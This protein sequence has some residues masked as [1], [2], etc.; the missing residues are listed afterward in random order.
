MLAHLSSGN[1]GIQFHSYE[2]TSGCILK[3]EV[4]IARYAPRCATL[5]RFAPYCG[6]GILNPGGSGVLEPELRQIVAP[7]VGR[8]QAA[9][10]IARP[11]L[12]RGRAR[13]LSFLF[14]TADEQWSEQT[15]CRSMAPVA[16]R[17][18]AA[19]GIARPN[20]RSSARP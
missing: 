15:S 13:S 3:H 7:V 11:D 18:Q 8:A 4:D 17:A 20:L 1:S 16:S 5:T 14:L 9:R 10:G 12:S 2:V 19:Q 6:T